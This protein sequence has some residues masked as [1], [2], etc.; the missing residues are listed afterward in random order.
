MW[1]HCTS[2]VLVAVL[3]SVSPSRSHATFHLMKIVEV[4]PGTAAEPDAQYVMLQM[5][6]P[7]Q[8]LVG[9]LSVSGFDANGTMLG[10]FTFASKVA[11]GADLATILIATSAAEALFDVTADLTMTPAIQTAGGAVCYDGIDCVTWGSF[12]APTALPIPPEAPFNP[13]GGLTLG[14][15]MHRDLSTGGAVTD[16]AFVPPAPKNNAGQ[17]GALPCVGDCDGNH[18]V[19]ID[20][21]LTLVNIALGNGQVSDC[22]VGDADGDKQITIDEIV[23]AVNNAFSSCSAE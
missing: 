22:T 7:G 13:S 20:E 19:T 23:A 18:Q 4:F 14:M 2:L 8:T 16:F 17:T 5:Y 10:K 11:N 12:S 15:A 3:L 21:I 6:S 1:R 9:G